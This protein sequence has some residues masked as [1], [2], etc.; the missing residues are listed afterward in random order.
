MSDQRQ[1]RKLPGL[2][3]FGIALGVVF[4]MGWLLKGGRSYFQSYLHEQGETQSTTHPKTYLP[5]PV[6]AWVQSPLQKRHLPEQVI[7]KEQF[8]KLIA[9]TSRKMPTRHDLQQLSS[10]QVHGTPEVISAAAYRMGAI[11]Q[12]LEQHPQWTPIALK[13]Y[14]DCSLHSDYPESLRAVCYSHVLEKSGNGGQLLRGVP[15][16][17]RELAKQLR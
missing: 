1:K 5:A 15:F 9:D 6:E 7:F 14:T 2:V 16:H 13:F 12:T 3:K 17:I 11:A 8:E 10:E 4:G